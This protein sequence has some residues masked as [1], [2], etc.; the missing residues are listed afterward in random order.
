MFY[1][2]IFKKGH[3]VKVKHDFQKPYIFEELNGSIENRVSK[4]LFYFNFMTFYFKKQRKQK[5]IYI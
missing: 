3:K 4:N 2:I 1:R 5:T